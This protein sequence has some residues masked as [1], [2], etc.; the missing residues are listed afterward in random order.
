MKRQIRLTEN[1]LHRIVKETVNRII[2]ETSTD[3]LYSAQKGAYKKMST[4]ASR[5]PSGDPRLKRAQDQYV[6]F[7]GEYDK[8][9]Q[10]GNTAKKARMMQNA[11]DI[12]IGRR[13]YQKGAGWKT[14]K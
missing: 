11:D 12:D 4:A 7:K 8:R 5:F 6:K 1:D 10:S 9:Y 13:T 2:S 14:K 3:T